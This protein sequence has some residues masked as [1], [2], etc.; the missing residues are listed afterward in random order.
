MQERE[1]S[2]WVEVGLLSTGVEFKNK[3]LGTVQ[4]YIGLPAPLMKLTLISLWG[5]L[6]NVPNYDFVVS[7]FRKG[8]WEK[9]Y[10]FFP[11]RYFPIQASILG[12]HMILSANQTAVKF[13]VGPFVVEQAR[14][15]WTFK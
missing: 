15:W 2:R 6:F 1:T 11:G 8:I 12:D 7:T 3:P 5:S 14:I 13:R 10:V 9:A 4:L